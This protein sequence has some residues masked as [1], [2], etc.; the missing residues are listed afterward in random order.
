MFLRSQINGST[1]LNRS[2]W[3]LFCTLLLPYHHDHLGYR[4]P[5]IKSTVTIWIG[6]SYLQI[7][8]TSEANSTHGMGYRSEL[9]GNVGKGWLTKLD[10]QTAGVTV[11]PQPFLNLNHPSNETATGATYILSHPSQWSFAFRI[12]SAY[13]VEGS[14]A[15]NYLPIIAFSFCQLHFHCTFRSAHSHIY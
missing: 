2:L 5:Y 14:A 11:I 8:T 15:T 12:I 9:C 4:G 1:K 3:V 10:P 6:S 13:S 7:C